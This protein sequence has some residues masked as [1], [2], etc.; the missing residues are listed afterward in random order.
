DSACVLPPYLLTDAQLESMREQTRQFSLELGVVG[1]INVQYAVFDG[2][3]YVLEVNPRASR[4][5]PFVSKAAGVPLA[6]IAAR[7]MV[8]ESLD[9]FGLPDSIPVHGAAV[10][11]SVFPFNKIEADSLLGP[12]MRSTGEAMGVDDSFAMAYAKAQISA[13][14]DL[15]S[16]GSVFVTVNDRDKEAVTPIVARLHEMGFRVMGTEGTAHYLNRLVG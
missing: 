6:R 9:S 3:V 13:G 12:E 2:E 8:G 14:N 10:K 4:T 5:V 16:G 15:P 7:L 1:L 11:E